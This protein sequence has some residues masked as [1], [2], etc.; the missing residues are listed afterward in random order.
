[1][2]R[3]AYLL[4]L[5]DGTLVNTSALVDQVCISRELGSPL[6][7]GGGRLTAGGRGLAGVDVAD[8]DHVDVHLLFT[9]AA[10]SML[11]RCGGMRRALDAPRLRVRVDSPHDGGC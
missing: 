3:R 8:D 10:I 2:R 5:L 7:I 9:A 6:A 4:E 1:M 11:C